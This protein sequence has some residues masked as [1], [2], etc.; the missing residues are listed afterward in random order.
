MVG[1]APVTP[2][3]ENRLRR[4]EVAASVVAAVG[5]I[6]AF[7]IAIS[8]LNIARDTLRDQQGINKSQAEVN[9]IEQARF[10]RRYASKVAIWSEGNMR[11]MYPLNKG[12][13]HIEN[14]SSAPL[15]DVLMGVMVEPTGDGERPR[16]EVITVPDIPPCSGLTLNLPGDLQAFGPSYRVLPVSLYFIDGAAVRWMR[17]ITGKLEQVP[18]A[19]PAMDDETF[20]EMTSDSNKKQSPEQKRTEREA[21]EQTSDYADRQFE[22]DSYPGGV[23]WAVKFRGLE[24]CGE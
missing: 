5:G 23:S 18:R 20:E 12:R 6:G 3:G 4:A 7:I 9:L 17:T 14:R 21:L 13:L 1:P 11:E 10:A 8:A 24:D 16:S 22:S 19:R 2:A 15:V